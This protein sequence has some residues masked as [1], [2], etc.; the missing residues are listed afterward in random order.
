MN[1]PFRQR[2]LAALALMTVAGAII[3]WGA[4]P[5]ARLCGLAALV[6]AAVCFALSARDL[7][8]HRS[9]AK[10]YIRHFAIAYA[11]Y[12]VVAI[13][14]AVLL[15]AWVIFAPPTPSPLL[16]PGGK[17]LRE[18]LDADTARLLALTGRAAADLPVCLAIAQTY[19]TFFQID[20]VADPAAHTDAFLLS[21]AALLRAAALADA[22]T[23]FASEHRVAIRLAASAAYLPVVRPHSPDNPLLPLIEADLQAVPARLL[24]PLRSPL[25]ALRRHALPQEHSRPGHPPGNPHPSGTTP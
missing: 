2:F 24:R 7:R 20:A 17:P 16:A 11:P 14:L 21:F 8:R 15:R 25:H 22:Q 6:A 1:P 4:H 3:V 9:H 10:T 23:P 5:F 19:Q 12:F 18:R 13:L